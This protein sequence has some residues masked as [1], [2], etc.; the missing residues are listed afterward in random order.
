MSN[1]TDSSPERKLFDYAELGDHVTVVA[2]I[3][4]HPRHKLN[5][6]VQ[7]EK[8]AGATPLVI[9]ARQGHAEVVRVLMAHPEIVVNAQDYCSE[10][11]LYSASV[12]GQA[13]CVRLLLKDPRVNIR[14]GTFD[15]LPPIANPA[16]HG[17]LGV[18]NEWIASGREVDAGAV[19]THT[20]K[21]YWNLS[22]QEIK[23]K[24][25]ILDLIHRFVQNPAQVRHEVR[26]E[27]GW[28]HEAADIFALV[29]FLCDGLL[30]HGRIK[31]ACGPG[32][33][34]ENRLTAAR[35]FGIAQGLPIEL[36]EQL[37]HLV[38]GWGADTIPA[39]EKEAAF[40]RLADKEAEEV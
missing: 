22:E 28:Y 11:A 25:L 4:G 18:I 24:S 21:P 23:N 13:G 8:Y 30:K 19:E 14:T 10:T 26:L 32:W 17:C 31:L 12:M 5:V 6:N 29:I 27:I 34:T 20:K 36:Q 1:T 40:C 7:V 15:W 2:M 9:A 33:N 38:A 3:R 37:C 35:F 39:E 16:W